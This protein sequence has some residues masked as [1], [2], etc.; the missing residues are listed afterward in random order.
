MTQEAVPGNGLTSHENGPVDRSATDDGILV[1]VQVTALY[2]GR[3]PVERL[4]AAIE[5]TL[6]HQ[7]R[8][9]GEVA[10]VICGDDL[11]QRLNWVFLDTDAPTDV[12]SFPATEPG[13]EGDPAF[14]T[15]PEAAGFLGDLVISYP[16]ALRQALAG[17]HDVEDELCLLAVHGTLHLLGHDHATAEEKGTMWAAQNAVLES[18]GVSLLPGGED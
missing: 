15:A 17:G 12:L 5:A 2:E 13:Q 16:M 10:L 4:V 3:V 18:L 8:E 14:V 7:G 1:D 6:R 9:A 11:L